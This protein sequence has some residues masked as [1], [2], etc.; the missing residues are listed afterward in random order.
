[1]PVRALL[2]G[3]LAD[4]VQRKEQ[5]VVTAF[6]HYELLCDEPDCDASFNAGEA[7]VKA[8]RE[9]AAKQ[10]WVHIFRPGGYGKGKTAMCTDYCPRHAER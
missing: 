3:A 6:H 2:Y 4:V 1:M 8:T 7:R 10:G 5:A 9:A